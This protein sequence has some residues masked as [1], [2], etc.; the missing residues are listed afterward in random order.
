LQTAKTNDIKHI[1]Q[2]DYS[3]SVVSEDDWTKC[4]AKVRTLWVSVTRI[5]NS[6]AVADEQPS[7]LA[8]TARML[9]YYPPATRSNDIDITFSNTRGGASIFGVLSIAFAALLAALAF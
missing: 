3:N 2:A 5:K 8:S 4:T 7:F 6:S 1:S 9:Q